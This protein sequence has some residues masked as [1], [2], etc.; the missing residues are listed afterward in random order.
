MSTFKLVKHAKSLNLLKILSFSGK[1]IFKML[2]FKMSH[3][4]E[5]YMRRYSEVNIIDKQFTL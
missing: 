2:V 3:H 5:I 4:L 1:I